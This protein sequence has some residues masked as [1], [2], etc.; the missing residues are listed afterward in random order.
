MGNQLNFKVS[1][2]L[3]NIIGRDLIINDT[4]AIFELVKNSFDA[5]AK[6]VQLYFDKDRI[7]IID[8]GHGMT[9]SDL[10]KKWLFVA[11]SE[12]KIGNSLDS[13]DYRNNTNNRVYA[14]SKGV[15]R[16]S[17]DRLGKTL[18]LQ[19]I[20]E[21]QQNHNEILDISW[22]KFESNDQNRF[23]E[24]K[25]L[26]STEN[27]FNLDEKK[28]S[29]DLF[30]DHSLFRSI[31]IPKHG[32]II[33][34]GELR[35][36]WDRKKLLELRKSLAK[37]I[38]PFQQKNDFEITILAPNELEQDQ[39]E[40]K[41]QL[42]N[43]DYLPIVNGPIKNFIFDTLESKST[44]LEVKFTDNGDYI[45][46]TL[47]D[48]GELIYKI[49]EPND[50]NLIKNCNFEASIYY[51]N[52]A[53]KMTFKRRM[54]VTSVSFGSIFVF[55]NGFR[56]FPIGNEG[57]DTFHLDRRKQQGYARYLG[58]REII[59][60]IDVNGTEDQF[61]EASSRDQGLI[62]TPAYL[63]LVECFMDK[64]IKRLETYVVEVTWKDSLDK[65]IDTPERLNTDLAK[66]RLINIVSKLTN[67]N[68]IELIEYS[69]NLISILNEKS[70][71]FEESLEGLKSL[72]RKA[73]DKELWDRI[74]KAEQRYL[75]LK[76]AEELAK[77][78][79]Y[80]AE[81]ARK[82]AEEAA[83]LAQKARIE[84]ERQKQHAEQ[85]AKQAE[86]E[87]QE[88]LAE[89]DKVTLAYEEEKKRNLFLT[90]NSSIDK[91]NI[92][93]LHH[94]IGIYSSS[95]HN[96]LANQIDKL[97]HNEFFGKEDLINIFEQ[98]TFKNQQILAVSRFATHANFRLQS[99]T[100]T[101]NL[102]LFIKEYLER[103]CKLYAGDI[104]Q[105]LFASDIDVFER[106]FLPIEL[107]M[108]IDNLVDNSRKAG[109][110]TVN[111]NIEKMNTKQIEIK[112]SDDGQG[113]NA[114][115]KNRIFE[116]GFSTTEGS[117]LGLYHV[118]HIIEQMGGSITLNETFKGGTQFII[119]LV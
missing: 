17:C 113:I 112:V 69:K 99:E 52:T 117:G 87:K 49:K 88:A 3:K 37:L 77:K 27:K 33:E 111:V 110:T 64:C 53:A 74:Y 7:I 38:N 119:R 93:N 29:I 61:K 4:V 100:I 90:A 40:V 51:L 43:E 15:G 114:L 18:K 55:R 62:E 115:E 60:K 72:A 66:A 54:G 81:E 21:S 19:T 78:E 20:H 101:E 23:E 71:Q 25:V 36:T 91:D 73:N 1:S 79:A 92:V 59:G 45:T 85:A 107:S 9:H 46:S 34:I 5:S 22:D 28:Y 13:S 95:I 50:F 96:L 14:G 97:N 105:I 16:F 102:I 94:Q 76:Q 12:K 11:Y 8:D 42:N 65:D 83:R 70:K 75:E 44:H 24:I 32:T 48:R 106:T 86:E 82:K 84:A 2:G 58:T 109:S 68:N 35:E 104:L 39:N 63:Q 10:V 98:L 56:V 108:V 26:N 118:K 80:E 41:S 67:T 30:Y 116:K 47:I 103:I 31:K 6:K 89:K 57:D